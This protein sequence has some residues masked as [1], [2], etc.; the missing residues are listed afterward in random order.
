[1]ML[2][3]NFFIFFFFKQKTAYEITYG[4]W[5]SDVCSSDLRDASLEAS[6]RLGR[7][8]ARGADGGARGR[9]DRPDERDPS[10]E[11]QPVPRD[12]ERGLVREEAQIEVVR[13]RDAEGD[14]HRDSGQRDEREFEQ[15]G[16]QHHRFS[17]AESAKGTGL[18][19]PLDDIAHRDDAEARDSDDQPEGEV[20]LEQVEHA[21]RR[22]EDRVDYRLDVHGDEL[23]GDEIP[24]QVMTRLRH[25]DAGAEVEV[26]QAGGIDPEVRLHGGREHPEALCELLI[27]DSDDPHAPGRA[28]HVAEVEDVVDLRGETPEIR[29]EVVRDHSAI[30][31]REARIL[32]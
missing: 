19:P 13:E 14:A 27:E 20:R 6:Q 16:F 1:M 24:L 32:V 3:L 17:E 30:D 11:Q 21:H 26:E 9:E 7:W 23:V 4:D 22:L 2:V 18:L 25:V 8:N 15:E 29:T 5:S 28:G 12:H 10:Q 31:D